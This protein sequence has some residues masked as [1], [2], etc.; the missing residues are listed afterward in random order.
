MLSRCRL[1]LAAAVFSLLLVPASRAD[2]VVNFSDLT[3]AANSYWNGPAP[4]GTVTTEDDGFF[5]TVTTSGTF[6]SGGVDF[7]NTNSKTYYSSTGGFAYDSWGNFAYSNMTNTTTPDFGNQYSSFAGGGLGDANFAIGNGYHDLVANALNPV[8]FDPTNVAQLAALPSIDLNGAS[9][10]GMYV[11]NTTYTALSMLYG[12][13]IPGG[14]GRKFGAGDWF[15]LSIFGIDAAGAA[16]SSSVEFYLANFLNGNSDV[17]NTWSWID[18]TPLAGATSL[19]F[20]L[21]SSDVDPLWGMNTPA[22]FALDNLTLA[23]P[24]PPA[25]VPEPSTLALAGIGLA[26]GAAVRLRRR[27]R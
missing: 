22:Y 25:V 11:T 1:A 18:L 2:S 16:L 8:A 4:G 20:N 13:T 6:S 10:L 19:H 23:G 14:F 26:V 21:S 24:T 27:S 5:T 12:D 7:N 15:K 3:L 9:A 17:V